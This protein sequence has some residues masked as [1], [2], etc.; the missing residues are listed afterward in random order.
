MTDAGEPGPE[1]AAA[2]A[3]AA[4][5]ADGGADGGADAGAEPG[6]A[7]STPPRSARGVELVG[8]AL[9]VL[10]QL[11]LIVL[12]LSFVVVAEDFAT[13]AISLLLWCLV[14]T[15]YT[16][17]ALIV[18]GRVARRTTSGPVQ[19]TR[20]ELSRWS[21]AVAFV[22]TILTSFVG[23][24]AAFGLAEFRE[25]PVWGGAVVLCSI[26]AMLLSWGQLHWG[27]AQLYYLQ[28]FRSAEPIL[29]FPGTPHPRIIEFVYFAYS[30]GTSFATS[31]VE[32]RS[33]ALRW[34][35]VWHSVLSFLFNGL[36]LVY[37]F[38]SLFA[39]AS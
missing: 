5:A 9:S 14:A 12:G 6:P 19:P 11:V 31:D 38:T 20:L 21:G 39:L 2:A 1:V 22:G 3:A 18:L 15:A 8:F 7:S 33:S 16:V 26:W 37:A 29:R 10:A 32:V 30:V 27:F 17:T 13:S 23:L 25:D 24:G 4:A 35:V 28:Y 36:I 34:R